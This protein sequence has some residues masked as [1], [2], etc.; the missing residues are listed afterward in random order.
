MCKRDLEKDLELCSKAT[1]EPW[2]ISKI[3]GDTRVVSCDGYGE[4][5]GLITV[6]PHTKNWPDSED[7]AK[8][9]AESREGWP[10]AI[11]R[12]LEAEAKNQRLRDASE[13]INK[14]LCS[15]LDISMTAFSYNAAIEPL[16]LAGEIERLLGIGRDALKE[17]T[18]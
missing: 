2:G 16:L 15:I 5:R 3:M 8:F 6:M 13:R 17:D 7:N 9:I 11:R 4:C 1:P 18:P 12:A 14:G 10:H